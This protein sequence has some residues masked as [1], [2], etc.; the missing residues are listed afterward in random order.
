M[1][2]TSFNPSPR[3]PE[4]RLPAGACDSHFHVFGPQA[5]FPFA[6]DRSYTPASD[7]PKETL[8]ALHRHLGIERGVVVQSA[9]H[10]FDN[11]AAADLI[12]AKP[13]A[14]RGIALVRVDATTDELRRLGR[15]GFVG[16]RFQFMKHLASGPGIEDI[17]SFAS[18]LA[19]VGWHLQVHME[20]E[21]IATMAPALLRSPVPVVIDHMGRVDASQGTG[22]EPFRALLRLLEDPKVWV[23]VSGSERISRAGSPWPD[24]V[25]FARRLVEGGGD[26]VVWG[27]DWPH[28]NL[29][30]V[31]DDGVLVDLLAQIAPTDAARRA[32]LVDNPRRLY[33]FA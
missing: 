2:A 16:A 6:A 15:Q 4:L 17:M 31:P 29:E 24:A 5:L 11:S 28:P 30:E 3:K 12:A 20:R 26:R 21:L 14:Y 1:T 32:V 7:A 25:P 22:Q 19:E 9:A 8:F 27:T 18:R 13:G 10:G 33:G 23:K